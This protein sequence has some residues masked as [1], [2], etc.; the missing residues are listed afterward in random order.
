MKHNFCCIKPY[1]KDKKSHE[2][3]IFV[4][5]WSKNQLELTAGQKIIMQIK[6]F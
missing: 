2:I 3:Q 6:E 1:R 5:G 4:H